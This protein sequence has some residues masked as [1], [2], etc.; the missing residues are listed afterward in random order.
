MKKKLKRNFWY[1]RTKLATF[2][3][4]IVFMWDRSFTA[5]ILFV[6]YNRY[7]SFSLL[8]TFFQTCI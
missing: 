2:L 7:N 3:W 6:F 5:V 8:D 1:F 4:A